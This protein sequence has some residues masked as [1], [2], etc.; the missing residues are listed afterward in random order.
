M[1]GE[2]TYV[3]ETVYRHGI[4][5]AICGGAAVMDGVLNAEDITGN[6]SERGDYAEVK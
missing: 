5:P 3:T 2:S 1:F 6:G 4:M